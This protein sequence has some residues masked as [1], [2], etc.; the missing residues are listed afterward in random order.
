MDFSC[1]SQI[2]PH[3][4]GNI[5]NLGV[6]KQMVWVGIIGDNLIGPYYFAGNV[7]SAAYAYMLEHFV[8]PELARLGYDP[9]QIY[10][11]HDG[12]PA[13]YTLQVR[14]FLT[15]HFAGWIGRGNGATITWPARSPDLNPLDFFLWGYVKHLIY[16]FPAENLE[17]L[18]NK[19]EEALD[20]ITPEMLRH[21]RVGLINRLLI[22]TENGGEHIEHILDV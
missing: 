21:V 10:Y 12:A 15:D 18:A 17:E 22:C 1:W 8:L 13:H 9:T 11:Q 19:I 20:N 2:N 6:Q 7:D 14:N 4:I 5:N 3:W 16:Q